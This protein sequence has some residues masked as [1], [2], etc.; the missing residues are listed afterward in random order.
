[1]NRIVYVYTN[2]GNA[3]IKKIRDEFKN[4]IYD[5]HKR[6]TK[7]KFCYGDKKGLTIKLVGFDGTVKK[8]YRKFNPKKI[9]KD[10]DAMPM[11][12]IKRK[13]LSLYA[14]YNPKSTIK[15]LGFKDKNKALH[16]IKVIKDM[17]YKYQMSVLNTM[18]NRALYHPHI[19]TD[20]RDAIKI[21]KV[22]MKNLKNRKNLL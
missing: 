22:Y 8:T 6:F 7:I 19:T 14:D 10:I 21:F 1:M 9:L 5:F 15:G 12:D 20:M 4:N 11:G 18:I 17:D 13:S 2:K 16:T 3:D